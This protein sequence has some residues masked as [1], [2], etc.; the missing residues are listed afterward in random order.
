MVI[1]RRIK[2]DNRHFYLGIELKY[3]KGKLLKKVNGSGFDMGDLSIMIDYFEKAYKKEAKEMIYDEE[4][5]YMNDIL[6]LYDRF[7]FVS[8]IKDV[9]Y[10]M[11]GNIAYLG[12][13][14]KDE[15]VKYIKEN[16]IKMNRWDKK[17][18]CCPLLY[19]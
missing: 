2:I 17:S 19:K 7:P 11:D 9:S 10:G 18:S 15:I 13:I 1:E 16:K 14:N 3:G 4:I 12:C 5:A 6:Y 8:Y